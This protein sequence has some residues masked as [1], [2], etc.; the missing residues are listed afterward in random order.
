MDESIFDESNLNCSN[1]TNIAIFQVPK[2]INEGV[3]PIKGLKIKIDFWLDQ[4]SELK[5]R[6]EFND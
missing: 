1:V 2:R 5:F 6:L 4:H 3:N